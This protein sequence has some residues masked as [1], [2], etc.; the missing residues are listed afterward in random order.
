MCMEICALQPW[1]YIC[2]RQT[3][4]H[5]FRNKEQTNTYTADIQGL[6]TNEFR[7]IREYILVSAL[8]TEQCL[9]FL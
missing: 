2:Q 5:V 8:K 6:D 4:Q 3:L 7:K 9:P 1:K